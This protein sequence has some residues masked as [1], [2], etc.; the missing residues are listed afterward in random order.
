M[1]NLYYIIWT[2]SSINLTFAD[3]TWILSG[4]W[5][6]EKIRNGD[7]H[8][9]DIP[10]IIVG[11]I[12]FFLWIAWTVAVIFV[13]IWAYKILMWWFSWDKWTKWKQTIIAALIGFALAALAWFIV[14]FIF[15][16]FG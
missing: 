6:S 14:R 5:D 13:I 15:D 4:L 10:K 3:D 12:D 16:N 9:E 2:I 7:I 8:L 1:K 11:A